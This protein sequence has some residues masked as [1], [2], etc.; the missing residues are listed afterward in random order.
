M[1]HYVGGQWGVDMCFSFRKLAC[2]AAFSIA[3]TI[4]LPAFADD[5]ADAVSASNQSLLD[6]ARKWAQDFTIGPSFDEAK[7][8]ADNCKSLRNLYREIVDALPRQQHAEAVCGS[9]L[10][11]KCNSSCVQNE[12]AKIKPKYEKA[13]AEAD[14]LN[15][16]LERAKSACFGNT[17]VDDDARF[18]ACGRLA[19]AA[20][21]TPEDRAKAYVTHG[22]TNDGRNNHDAAFKDYSEAIRLH[23]GDEDALLFRA[24]EYL[25]QGK[26]DLAFQDLTDGINANPKSVRLRERR[27]GIFEQRKDY[28]SA[29]AEINEAIKYSPKDSPEVDM[30]YANRANLYMLKGDYDQAIRE[31]Q[32]LSKRDAMGAILGE[33]GIESVKSWRA[34]RTKTASPTPPPAPPPTPSVPPAVTPTPKPP[35]QANGTQEAIPPAV[36]LNDFTT[37]NNRDIYGNDIPAP[38]GRIG[39]QVADI[40]ECAVRCKEASSCVAF[41][42]DRWKGACYLKNNVATSI[43][44]VHSILAVKKPLQLPT[45]SAAQTKMEI[46]RNRKLQGDAVAR[47]AVTT[48]DACKTSCD[49]DLRCLGFNFTKQSQ[50]A[51]RCEMLKSLD[52]SVADD[53]IDA[54][55]KTQ[56]ADAAVEKAA[57]CAAAETH[58]K[59]AERIN[60][61]EAYMDHLNRFPNCAFATMAKIRIQQLKNSSLVVPQ[62]ERLERHDKACEQLKAGG[63][64]CM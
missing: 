58:W 50:S 12:I 4:S 53:T 35:V 8:A 24:G 1:A 51:S 54:G 43:L 28:D 59:S 49:N 56:A 7:D 9:R 19:A 13:C 27:A 36:A 33:S 14:R 31:Y 30:T 57:D 60:T 22:M 17:F 39:L 26:T 55:Y 2:A 18:Q 61:L 38:N 63:V 48:F 20:D 62:I 16:P 15:Q 41:S 10:I 45:V 47:S 42:F 40:N 29:I 25:L 32:A 11:T 23:P 64:T 52:G 6:D 44:D 46:A 37:R 5:C 34:M 3:A 21:A